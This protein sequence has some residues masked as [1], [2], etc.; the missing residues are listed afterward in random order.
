[1]IDLKTCNEEQLWK[2][3]A[4]ELAK[5]DVDVILVG[6]AV[7]SIYTDGAYKSGDLDFVLNDFT[8]DELNRVL[9]SLGFFQEGRHFKHPD[10]SQLFIEFASFPAGIGEDYEITPAQVENEG[11]ILKIYSPTDCVRDRLASYIHFDSQECLEQ[12]WMVARR[13]PINLKLVEKWCVGEK[14]EKQWEDFIAGLKED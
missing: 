7:V 8:R 1:M 9:N 2:Y 10:C 13:H 5:N 14:G 3:V 6:G 12:A 4:T 11:Q